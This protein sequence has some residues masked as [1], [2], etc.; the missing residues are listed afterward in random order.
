MVGERSGGEQNT[1]A[2]GAVFSKEMLEITYNY[3]WLRVNKT[4]GNF[5]V[6]FLI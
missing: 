3:G 5:I 1:K 2:S 6:P 4:E